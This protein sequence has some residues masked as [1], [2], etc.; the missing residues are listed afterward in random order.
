LTV[1]NAILREEN[2]L[3]KETIRQMNS[4]ENELVA[5]YEVERMS[6]DS[7]NEYLK[8]VE[9]EYQQLVNEGDA[10]IK[11]LEEKQVLVDKL[12]LQTKEEKKEYV[13]KDTEVE[14]LRMQLKTSTDKL[15]RSVKVNGQL[16][17][18]VNEL[19]KLLMKKQTNDDDIDKLK[20][21][22][23]ELQSLLHKK[24]NCIRDVK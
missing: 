23:T 3:M 5:M 8:S 13:H 20:C 2:T 15:E 18:E 12:K 17:D 9:N 7:M 22:V 10:K 6:V 14:E 24:D 4:K 1:E 16:R 11:Q 21:K 19:T